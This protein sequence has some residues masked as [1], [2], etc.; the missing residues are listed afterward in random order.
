MTKMMKLTLKDSNQ[1]VYINLE[2]IVAIRSLPDSGTHIDSLRSNFTVKQNRDQILKA[3]D[4][5]D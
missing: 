3:I 4:D 1:T 5:A 2:H